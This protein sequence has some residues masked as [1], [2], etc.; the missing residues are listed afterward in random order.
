VIVELWLAILAGLLLATVGSPVIFALR[1]RSW[2][3]AL[4]VGIAGIAIPATLITYLITAVQDHH[5][6]LFGLFVG[7]PALS[8]ATCVVLTVVV[9]AF[10]RQAVE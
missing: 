3:L 1:R 6:G 7:V 8:L 10:T 2:R 4:A 9:S 5:D